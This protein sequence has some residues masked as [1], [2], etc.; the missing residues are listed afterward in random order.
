LVDA[1][2]GLARELPASLRDDLLGGGAQP[3]EDAADDADDAWSN[4]GG[5]DYVGSLPLIAAHDAEPEPD[6]KPVVETEPE[7]DDP[8]PEVI[9]PLPT[10]TR[11]IPADAVP[12][13]GFRYDPLR[14]V[15]W[16]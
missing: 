6:A 2:P 13:R 14:G 3:A 10:G 16:R 11:R 12:N 9:V 1:V 4:I 7:P 5:P 8:E 15:R